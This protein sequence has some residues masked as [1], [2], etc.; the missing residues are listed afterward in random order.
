MKKTVLII[1]CVILVLIISFFI[2][3]HWT[4]PRDENPIFR[5]LPAHTLKNPSGESI[6]IPEAYPDQDYL[7]LFFVESSPTSLR[8]LTELSK[9][10]DR[11]AEDLTLI[12]IHPGR[13]SE[14]LPDWVSKKLHLL[15]D[16]DAVFTRS[17]GIHTL[18]TLYLLT[19]QFQQLA[20][21][22]SLVPTSILLTYP[23][24]LLSH[25]SIPSAP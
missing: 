17:M 23:S 22:E 5:P 7:L 24:L 18:P 15:L 4:T 8:Q 13:M 2:I 9:V 12:L 25:H 11:L 21:A 16:P 6:Q 1:G 20:F 14:A 10:A 19:S 3:R